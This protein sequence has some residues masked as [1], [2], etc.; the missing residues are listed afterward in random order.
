MAWISIVRVFACKYLLTIHQFRSVGQLTM[1]AKKSNIY[2][3]IAVC[4]VYKYIPV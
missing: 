3:S 1:H 4:T 2:L